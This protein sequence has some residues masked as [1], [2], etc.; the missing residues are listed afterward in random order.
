MARRI[1]ETTTNTIHGY[2]CNKAILF[3]ERL[4]LSCVGQ[5]TAIKTL[6]G[7]MQT[8][9]ITE[10]RLPGLAFSMPCPIWT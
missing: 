2:A 5:K 10:E 3:G 7:R 4:K 8:S 9:S 1:N 6:A